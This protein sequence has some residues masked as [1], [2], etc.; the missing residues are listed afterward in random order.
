VFEGTAG[1]R[2]VITVNGIGMDSLVQARE[3]AGE[4]E[5]SADDDS[6]SELNSRLEYTVSQSGR[7]LVKVSALGLPEGSYTLTVTPVQ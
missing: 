4:G 1:Q 3:E 7:Q 5:W 6:G 2:F